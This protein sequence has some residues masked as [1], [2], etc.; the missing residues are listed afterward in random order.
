MRAY[1]VAG[2]HRHTPEMEQELSKVA[3]SPQRVIFT[4][5]LAPMIR[6]ILTTAYAPAKG[7]VSVEQCV[8]AARDLLKGELVSVLPAGRLPDTLH[9]RGSGRVQIGYA[10]D[11]RTGMILA[12]A[13]ID[14]LARGASSQALHALN[15]ARGFD[16][17]LGIP[18]I[19][20]F[21]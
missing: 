7:E 17:V 11:K 9:V 5:Q 6:G 1:K 4:P 16:E 19:A 2:T 13:A 10:V 14:N 20:Q 3:G 8:Q 21:P 18:R 15:V 12:I